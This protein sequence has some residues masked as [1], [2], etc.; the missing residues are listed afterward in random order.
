MSK[1]P[2][3]S[4][5]LQEVRPPQDALFGDKRIFVHALQFHW[6]DYSQGAMDVDR[7]AK[8]QIMDLGTF[9]IHLVA[10]TKACEIDLWSWMQ[11]TLRV[12]EVHQLVSQFEALIQDAL[13]QFA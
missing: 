6:H 11:D 5:V 8:N 12:L 13:A 10:R 2:G 4:L 9:C 7:D 3:T 1:E